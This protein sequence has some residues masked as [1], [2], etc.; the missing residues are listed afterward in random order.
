MSR[1]IWFRQQIRSRGSGLWVLRAVI[2]EKL[3]ASAGVIQWPIGSEDG[4]VGMVD[5]IEQVAYIWSGSGLGDKFESRPILATS[6]KR[7]RASEE[8]IDRV[9]EYDD[10]LTES[11]WKAKRSAPMKFA[12]R[13]DRQLCLE[14]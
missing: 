10:E 2:A 7:R 8:I 5:V 14:R 13:S 4:F 3:G 11:T 9:S 6:K 12:G 1:E